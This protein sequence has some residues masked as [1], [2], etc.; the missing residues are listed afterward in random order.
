MI[1]LEKIIPEGVDKSREGAVWI[2][3]SKAGV[4]S[5]EGPGAKVEKK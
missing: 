4:S 1:D 2:H 3:S 5:S